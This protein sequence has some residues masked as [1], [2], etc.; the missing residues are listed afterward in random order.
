VLGQLVRPL[1]GDKTL[2]TPVGLVLIALSL[3]I[4]MAAYN[5]SSNILFMTLSLL[6][7]CLILSGVLAWMN[8]HGTRWRLLVSPRLRAG[9]RTS[10]A[11]DLVNSK[12]VL[13]TYS[14]CFEVAALEARQAGLLVQE[15]GLEPGEQIRLHWGYTPPRRG[16]ETV[17]ITRLESQFPFGF[18][19]KCIGGGLQRRVVVWP[20]HIRYAFQPPPGSPWQR[21]G[22]TLPSAG[23]GT[24]LINLRTYR[25]G[26]PIRIVHWKASARLRRLM[27]R[28]T[29]EERQNAYLLFLETPRSVWHDPEQ[30]EVL[31]RA[32]A[33]LA[34]DLYSRGQLWGAA[35]N[36]EPVQRI[37]GMGDLHRFW[38]RLASLSPADPY[39]PAERF[40]G[41]TV[42]TFAPGMDRQ[43]TLYVGAHY[44]GATQADAP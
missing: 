28:E 35:V 24:E 15:A 44:A 8:L 32:A 31:C 16:V 29:S 6:L 42:I 23:H 41:A 34:E 22:R 36:D 11:V 40:T 14:L 33:S 38:D 20:Q 27:A 37:K 7:S 30:F 39:K 2:P 18:L 43:V 5:T 21:E 9:E 10:V 12:K 1:K 19:R 13:P 17:A 3:G 4:G 25:P 26:D